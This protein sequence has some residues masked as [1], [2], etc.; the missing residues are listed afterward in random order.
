MAY[1]MLHSTGIEIIQAIQARISMSL[2]ATQGLSRISLLF[3]LYINGL[4][5]TASKQLK[6]TTF[7]DN[8]NIFISGQNLD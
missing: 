4:T 7:A 6:F 1:E 5:D 3:I 8:T 2:L